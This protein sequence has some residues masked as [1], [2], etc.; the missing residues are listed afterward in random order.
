MFLHHN[1]ASVLQIT[2]QSRD[3]TNW[4][5]LTRGIARSNFNFNPCIELEMYAQRAN[6]CFP[7][8]LKKI[9]NLSLSQIGIGPVHRNIL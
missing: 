7:K 5:H 9:A 6:I 8:T 3:V 2:D 1:S 4:H